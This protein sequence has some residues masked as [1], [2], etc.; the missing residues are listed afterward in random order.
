MQ[1][2]TAETTYEYNGE[3]KM[4]KK[5]VIETSEDTAPAVTATR[6]DHEDTDVET[7]IALESTYEMSPLEVF[8]TAAVGALVGSLL[9]QAIR[10]D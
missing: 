7:D 6:P 5:T 4:S 9:Y 10:K 2:Y 3:G 1:K 8:M